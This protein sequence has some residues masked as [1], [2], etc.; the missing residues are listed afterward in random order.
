MNGQPKIV[1]VDLIGDNRD[2][3][4]SVTA[5]ARWLGLVGAVGH[6]EQTVRALFRRKKIT[7]TVIAGKKM[8]RLSWLEEY[9]T[10][11]I[12]KPAR[13]G[14]PGSRGRRRHPVA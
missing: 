4:L 11:G 14:K 10:A 8:T 6:P 5:A 12:G 1:A 7:S 3:L 2:P 9:V 13:K